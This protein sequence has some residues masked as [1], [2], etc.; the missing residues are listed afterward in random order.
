MTRHLEGVVAQLPRPWLEDLVAL[1]ARP[2]C[3]RDGWGPVLMVGAG[4]A[5]VTLDLH[6]PAFEQLASQLSRHAERSGGN[7]PAVWTAGDGGWQAL[8][9]SGMRPGQVAQAL[10]DRLAVPGLGART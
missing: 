9:V 1:G 10:A 8:Q 5:T 2:G 6:G 7:T 4:G 3:P